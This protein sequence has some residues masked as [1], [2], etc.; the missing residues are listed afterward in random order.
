MFLL[1]RHLDNSYYKKIVYGRFVSDFPENIIQIVA[2]NETQI[3]LLIFDISY[4]SNSFQI[5]SKTN[6]RCTIIDAVRFS[7]PVQDR[8]IISVMIDHTQ[9]K[10]KLIIMEFD[11]QK[12]I[13]IPFTDTILN[14]N[15]KEPLQTIGTKLFCR[16]GHIISNTHLNQIVFFK[17][18]PI[19]KQITYEKAIF[20]EGIIIDICFDLESKHAF[21]LSVKG[22]NIVLMSFFLYKIKL[23]TQQIVEMKEIRDEKQ[24][25]MALKIMCISNDKLAVV[26]NKILMVISTDLE[27]NDTNNQTIE[28]IRMNSENMFEEINP[29]NILL[30]NENQFLITFEKQ[31]T[32]YSNS[33]ENVTTNLSLSFNCNLLPNL[34]SFDYLERMNKKF[35]ISHSLQGI[36]IINII[37]NELN[38]FT[39]NLLN[40]VIDAVFNEKDEKIYQLIA[41]QPFHNPSH[42][43]LAEYCVDTPEIFSGNI[44]E[45]DGFITKIKLIDNFIFVEIDRFLFLYEFNEKNNCLKAK[46]KLELD[47]NTTDIE[48]S[49]EEG[50]F[51]IVQSNKI[52]KL[53]LINK[54]DHERKTI[55]ERVIV[56]FKCLRE[57]SIFCVYSNDSKAYFYDFKLNPVCNPIIIPFNEISSINFHDALWITT[58]NGE[59]Y[60]AK[61]D[62]NQNDDQNNRS[63][64][65]K[66]KTENSESIISAYLHLDLL[67]YSTADSFFYVFNISLLQIMK[68]F[69]LNQPCLEILPFFDKKIVL[70]GKYILNVNRDKPNEINLNKLFEK[71]LNTNLWTVDRNSQYLVNSDGKKLTIFNLTEIKMKFKDTLLPMKKTSR[72]KI[73][74]DAI[75]I[76]SDEDV[77][78][79]EKNF[80]LLKRIAISK[81]NNVIVIFSSS[82]RF[83]LMNFDG[84]IILQKNLIDA[85]SELNFFKIINIGG[86]EIYFINASIN[87][88]DETNCYEEGLMRKENKLF[89]IGIER[90]TKD[91]IEIINYLPKSQTIN[92][93]IYDIGI[94]QDLMIMTSVNKL[95]VYNFK[96]NSEKE[97]FDLNLIKKYEQKIN[98]DPYLISIISD[99]YFIIGDSKRGAFIFKIAKKN[100]NQK[101]EIELELILT[102][103]DP[104]PISICQY[105]HMKESFIFGIDKYGDIFTF[106]INNDKIDCNSNM[107]F[108]SILSLKNSS[109]NFIHTPKNFGSFE[110]QQEEKDFKINKIIR[111]MSYSLKEEEQEDEETKLTEQI[112]TTGLSKT[113][114]DHK[115]LIEEKIIESK[116]EKILNECEI[117]NNSNENNENLNLFIPTL[118]G[119]LI[120]IKYCNLI[121]LFEK[122]DFND[123]MLEFYE[124]ML[125][126]KSF[127]M[128]G[129]EDALFNEYSKFTKTKKVIDIDIIEEYLNDQPIIQKKIF[130]MFLKKKEKV[131]TLVGFK[132]EDVLKGCIEIIKISHHC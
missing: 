39:K 15:I 88:I 41:N 120:E 50:E 76:F 129:E 10:I 118:L 75:F 122:D 16:G 105:I 91:D 66:N 119:G 77:E 48:K 101:I 43:K 85:F 35:L 21:I 13:F 121:Y 104:R 78:I 79:E 46:F 80:G 20:V 114:L 128:I 31:I 58:Y 36:Q 25:D 19:L 102:Q 87:L 103:K 72:T 63:F 27:G 130:E 26:T 73:I 34:I 74:N 71:N 113:Y 60:S 7:T 5:I 69:I 17:F 109:R 57:E 81:N 52:E 29:F 89:M 126:S 59:I 116:K 18:E 106:K 82:A 33:L 3:D 6:L 70:D 125:K 12:E 100:L 11:N 51:F 98:F 40:S 123:F 86:Q 115:F 65:L 23:K 1:K 14:N 55:L 37:E 94:I 99:H 131:I 124:F 44:V 28:F 4:P 96:Y 49:N 8:L 54:M 61:I 90:K 32:F 45:Y 56:L 22:K 132:L 107:E 92:E 68:K 111:N 2:I 110:V 30:M 117:F 47:S 93:I 108:Q 42:L 127:K 84:E 24:F 67:L 83:L 64:L 112:L 38:Y 53:T 62:F 95:L 97:T 9:L